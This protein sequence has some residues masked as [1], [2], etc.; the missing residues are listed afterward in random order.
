MILA[1][2]TN[3]NVLVAFTH[4][5]VQE[6]I[7]SLTNESLYENVPFFSSSECAKTIF[8]G[9]G[10]YREVDLVRYQSFLKPSLDTHQIIKD[11]VPYLENIYRA[12]GRLYK[13]QEFHGDFLIAQDN[14]LF[15]IKD[16]KTVHIIDTYFVNHYDDLT[17]SYLFI[18]RHLPIKEKLLKV[19]EDVCQQNSIQ[20]YP[21]LVT[22]T[23]SQQI[24]IIHSRE[25][26]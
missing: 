4:N 2:K 12:Y 23:K 8:I 22:D 3:D 18:H 7:W 25:D 19:L 16:D 9:V 14:E 1:L 20:A 26:L 11:I 5:E 24:K 15:V 17:R 10:L 21:M 6:S 13:E